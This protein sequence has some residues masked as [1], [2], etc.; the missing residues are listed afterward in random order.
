MPGLYFY[1]NSVLDIARDLALQ[2]LPHEAAPH[3]GGE[4]A[5]EE[6][7]H[8]LERVDVGVVAHHARQSDH[9]PALVDV[10]LDPVHAGR[11]IG[12]RVDALRIRGVLRRRHGIGRA[13]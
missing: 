4:A 10:L 11:Q 2:R 5:A 8:H 7:V 13:R 6:L 1:D 9:D 12:K 3:E